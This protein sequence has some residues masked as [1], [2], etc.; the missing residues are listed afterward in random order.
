MSLNIVVWRHGR[1]GY[2]ISIHGLSAPTPRKS[3]TAR[4]ILVLRRLLGEKW[5]NYELNSFLHLVLS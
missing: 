2:R 1:S 4:Q 5:L 3:A